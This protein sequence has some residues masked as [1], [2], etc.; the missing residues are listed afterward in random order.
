M[1]SAT[2]L[3][4]PISLSQ[5]AQSPTSL[6]MPALTDI[7]GSTR[8]SAAWITAILIVVST[9]YFSVATY[10]VW[11]RLRHIPGPPGTGLSRWW[12]LR[13]TLQGNLHLATKEACKK[14]GKRRFV[15]IPSVPTSCGL[16]NT[17]RDPPRS[18]PH[19][20]C[21]RSWSAFGCLG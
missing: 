20:P 14:Y 5:P 3:L 2:T 13:N 16:C 8:L 10:S 4:S 7:A 21:H 17:E 15:S 12:M 6:I 1:N 9:I 19:L 18:N 11:R